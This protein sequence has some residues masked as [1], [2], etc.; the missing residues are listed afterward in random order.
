MKKEIIYFDYKEIYLT[1]A[2]LYKE[3]LLA[4]LINLKKL[5]S[6]NNIQFINVFIF[7]EEVIDINKYFS[8]FMVNNILSRSKNWYQICIQYMEFLNNNYKIIQDK[9]ILN[10][11]LPD[12]EL[13]YIDWIKYNINNFEKET[14]KTYEVIFSSLDKYLFNKE[15]IVKSWNYIKNVLINYKDFNKVRDEKFSKNLLIWDYPAGTWIDCL[16]ENWYNIN[17]S[18][19]AIKWMN[20][21]I[22]LK[23]LK[24]NSQIEAENY[25]PKFSRAKLVKFNN[26]KIYKIYISWTAAVSPEWKTLYSDDINENIKYTMNTVKL[27]LKEAWMNFDNIVTSFVYIKRPEY[28]NNYLKFYKENQFNFPYIYTFCDICRD[29]WLFEFECV[30]YNRI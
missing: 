27:L 20:N 19:F 13:L 26:D 17:S 18:I 7:S 10:I 2:F 23:S 11:K 12:R 9:N 22:E 25:W 30:A 15:N 1:E 14:N 21:S 5:L 16:L 28:L 4:Y 3:D 6:L 29:D 24:V 8:Y